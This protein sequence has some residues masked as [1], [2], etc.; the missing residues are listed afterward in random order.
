[1]T[2][3][4]LLSPTLHQSVLPMRTLAGLLLALTGA[5]FN[6]TTGIFGK[7]Q[8]RGPDVDLFVFH[9]WAC[10][11][12]AL[13]AALVLLFGSVTWTPLGLLS[14]GLLALSLACS[15]SAN[16]KGK[17]LLSRRIWLKRH[18]TRC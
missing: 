8:V 9:F 16:S 17:S 13:T 18:L 6:G 12:V 2:R 14:G 10:V 3:A 5:I 1:M 4:L 7:D 11:G 15:F